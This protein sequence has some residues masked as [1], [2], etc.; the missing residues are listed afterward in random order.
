MTFDPSQLI[1]LVPELFVLT[2]ASIALVMDTFLRDDQRV[3]TYA[4]AQG[5]IVA[6]AILCVALYPEGRML[7]FNGT[8]VSDQ[9]SA[10]L[11]IFILLVSYFVFVYS[12]AYLNDR[13]LFKGEYFV[14]GLFAI[15]GMMVLVS[16]HS[17]LTLYL[18]L[19]LLSLSLYAMVGLHRE[20]VA[21]SEAAMK[22]FVL[23]ALSSGMLLYGISILYGV[24]G[25]LDLDELAQF[26]AQMGDDSLLAVFG[27]VFVIVGIAFKLGAVPFHMWIPD[28]YE[29]A[30][31]SVTLFIGTAPKL[32]AFAMLMRFLVDGLSG[33]QGDWIQML[34]ILA[35]LSMGAGN[36]IAIAQSNLKRML[37]YST[38]A[39][40]GF[41]LLGVIAATAEGYA[42]ALFYTIVYAIMAMG[43]FGMIILLSRKG[44]EADRLEDFKGLNERSPWAAFLMLI[45]MFSMGGVPPFLGFWAKWSVL[46][47]I[48]NADMVWLA[49]VAVFFAIIGLFY[50]LRVVRLM[51]FDM[52]EDTV[53]ITHGADMKVMI[54]ANALVILLLGVYPGGLL[55]LC[56]AVVPY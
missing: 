2:M 8:F 26:V 13:D 44:F 51:Y 55:A 23:G 3:L 46:R 15:L 33:V 16:G 24:S 14:L 54:S 45:L 56:S 41:L 31:T 1:P 27:L 28:V 34:V 40:V 11:K 48:V 12:R 49:A 30:P 9:M 18:G 37:A 42:A 7:A 17:L 52:P 43:G 50:Y 25:T 39:H 19:E 53:P 22:Y 36:I 38:I 47:E 35:I 32:A 29:G 20:S 10:V 5:T 21:A 6:A 4:I